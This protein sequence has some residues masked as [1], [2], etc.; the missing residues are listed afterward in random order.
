VLAIERI[1]H[2]IEH[3]GGRRSG[4]RDH[5]QGDGRLAQRPLDFSI[6]AGAGRDVQL[7]NPIAT[8]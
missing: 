7:I 2:F 8:P 3:I 4:S 1:R 6:P 5:D